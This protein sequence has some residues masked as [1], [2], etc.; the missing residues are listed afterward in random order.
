MPSYV[1]SSEAQQDLRDINS[2][3]GEKWGK[4]QADNYLDQLSMRFTQLAENPYIGRERPELLKGCRSVVEGKHLILY[5]IQEQT[6]I[7]IIAIPHCSRDIMHYMSN[8][9]TTP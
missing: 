7:E 4:A 1:L 8:I 6:G 9:K 5:R 3:T 2:Y